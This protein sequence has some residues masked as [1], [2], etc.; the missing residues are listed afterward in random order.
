[1][2]IIIAIQVVEYFESSPVHFIINTNVRMHTTSLSV[3][4]FLVSF[5][6]VKAPSTS[7]MWLDQF[8]PRNCLHFSTIGKFPGAQNSKNQLCCTQKVRC[9]LQLFC[10]QNSISQMYRKAVLCKSCFIESQS[11]HACRD[12][13][14][15]VQK[16]LLYIDKQ[17]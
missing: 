1:M 13:R 12:N 6:R 2:I 9:I 14:L 8:F 5:I 11:Q 17:L 7:P 16:S 3:I 15:V 4:A 10:V